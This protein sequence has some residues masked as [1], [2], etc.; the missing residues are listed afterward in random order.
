MTT[1][2][3]TPIERF[4]QLKCDIFSLNEIGVEEQPFRVASL[5]QKTKMVRFRVKRRSIS[6]L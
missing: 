6:S 4:L 2:G 5:S 3:G 1:H